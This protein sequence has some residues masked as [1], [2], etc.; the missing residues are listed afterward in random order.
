MSS[1]TT[2][3]G[4]RRDLA[5]RPGVRAGVFS[6]GIAYDVIGTGSRTVVFLPGGPGIVPMAWNRVGRTLLEPLAASGYT[7]WRLARRSG[8]PAGHSL[9]DMADDVARVIDEAFG[10][11][12]DVVVGLSMGGL[13]AQFLAARHP[14]AA[15]RVVLLSAAAVPTPA[16][17]E[18]TR[19]EGEAWGHG[20]YNEAGAA[21]FED[22]L[23]GERLGWLRRLLGVPMGRMLAKS[24]THPADVL[25]ETAAVMDVDARPVLPGITAPVLLIYGEKDTSFAPDAVDETARLIPDCTLIRYSERGHGGAAWDKRTPG[26]ILDFI[27]AGPDG[28]LA[29]TSIGSPAATRQVAVGNLRGGMLVSLLSRQSSLLAQRFGRPTADVMR[30]EIREEYRAL[31]PGLPDLGGRRNPESMSLVLMP[32]SLALYR[33]VRRHG[34]SVQDAGEVLHDSV[35]GLYGRI[36]QRMRR[37]MGRSTTRERSQAKVRWFAEN[38]YPD[39]WIYEFVDGDGHD[40]DFGLDVTQCAIVNYLHAQGADELTPYLCDLDYVTFAAVGV[41]LTRTRTLAWGCDRCDF[42]VTN[43]GTTTSTWPPRFPERSCGRSD[44]EDQ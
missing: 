18:S 27:T 21:M 7:V 37:S 10:G 41:G 36:P 39:N 2:T 11:R 30:R 13:I 34:G 3:T 19:R 42:R 16:T 20:R 5:A 25:V 9:E 32:W 6:N 35:Q 24:P 40:F 15:G 44:G 33:V 23:P 31:V 28:R 29:A 26:H 12:V 8:M 22:V 1:H 43:P 4:H 14:D 38:P 17:V